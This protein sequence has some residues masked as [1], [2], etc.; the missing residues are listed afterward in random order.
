MI[1]N[2]IDKKDIYKQIEE[3]NNQ[4]SNPSVKNSVNFAKSY[5]YVDSL[6]AKDRAKFFGFILKEYLN[7]DE[8]KNII[9]LTF[10]SGNLTAHLLLENSIYTTNLILND[11]FE[12]KNNVNGDINIGEKRYLDI[13]NSENFN[14]FNKFDLIVFNP[15][16]GGSYSSGELAIELIEPKISSENIEDYI[17][18]SNLDIEIN[19]DEEN[20]KFFIH[21]DTLS[22]SAMNDELKDIKIYNYYDVFYQSKNTKIEGNITNIVKFRKTL[23]LISNDNNI[24]VFYG[25]ENHFNIF[26]KDYKYIR[27]L[28]NNGNDLFIISKQFDKNICYEKDNN[29]EFII[30][31]NCEKTKT[32]SEDEKGNIEESIKEFQKVFKDLQELGDIWGSDEV[33]EEK[34][35]KKPKKT[36][37][38]FLNENL[39][40]DE[41]IKPIKNF[42]KDKKK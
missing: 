2:D 9:D 5:L 24:L 25:K 8:F 1:D 11:K 29:N 12:N 36:I 22:K 6:I 37:P 41:N 14:E 20:R 17:N 16:I 33:K 30:N 40:K 42:L 39:K 38:N 15:Q 26:F 10:G 35:S 34:K 31:E 18:L 19:I 21:S 3:F 7:I 13:L 27:Y 32:K 4:P 28:A 23:D